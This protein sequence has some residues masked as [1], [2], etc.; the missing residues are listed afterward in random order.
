[1]RASM[2][3]RKTTE[4]RISSISSRDISAPARAEASTP[5]VSPRRQ[6]RQPSPVK[7]ARAASTSERQGQFSMTLSPGASRVAA[8]M[9]RALFLAPC[10]VRRPS[11]GRPPRM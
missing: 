11:S 2:A 3:P 6:T 9:G 8:R 7:M 10:T 1:M 5:T 4:E